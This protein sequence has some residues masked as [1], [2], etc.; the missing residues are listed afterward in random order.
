MNGFAS[1]I[2]A[3][4]STILAMSL[5]FGAVLVLALGLYVLALATLSRLLPTA[6]PPGAVPAPEPALAGS[7]S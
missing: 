2:G 1:V 6:S 4:L 5:G 3:V 7:P